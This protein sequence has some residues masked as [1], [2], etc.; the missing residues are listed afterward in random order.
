MLIINH[1][2]NNGKVKSVSKLTKQ[3][4]AIR[5]SGGF[6]IKQIR[7]YRGQKAI[8]TRNGKT[9]LIETINDHNVAKLMQLWACKHRYLFLE[10]DNEKALLTDN[11]GI[12]VYCSVR[13][14]S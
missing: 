13:E 4:I 5:L 11:N 6:I 1:V 8:F 12:D 2:G 9:Y 14:V 3:E 10:D 7:L